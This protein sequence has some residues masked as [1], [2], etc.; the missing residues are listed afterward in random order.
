MNIVKYKKKRAVLK[1]DELATLM[2]VYAQI[3]EGLKGV[4]FVNADSEKLVKEALDVY[5]KQ[6]DRIA[7]KILNG[8]GG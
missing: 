2:G 7:D 3:E 4:L 8:E 5:H 6:L 1:P